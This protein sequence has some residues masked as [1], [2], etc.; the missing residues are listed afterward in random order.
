MAIVDSGLAV[1]VD[2]DLLGG[3]IGSGIGGLGTMF[4]ETEKLLERGP[5]RV[6]PF[7]VPMM[8]GNMASGL[9]AIRYRAKGVNLPVV[10]ACA[11][12]THAIGEAYRA[13][14]HGYADAIIA[15]GAEAAINPISV[16]GFT[17]S[18]ALTTSTDPDRASIPFARER[19][20]VLI[21]EEYER[22]KARGAHIYAEIA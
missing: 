6:S 5:R 2:E 19:S 14:G 15:G 20:G 16:A 17:S 8:I 4:Q 3:Y 7:L 12:A 13:I 21:L 11:T 18:M 10:T 1:T 9:A 22:A